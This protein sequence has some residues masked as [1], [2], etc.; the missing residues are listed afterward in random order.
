AALRSRESDAQSAL[1]RGR[2]D[3]ARCELELREAR[4]ILSEAAQQLARAK[5]TLDKALARAKFESIEA[6]RAAS[7]ESEAR[8][9]LSESLAAIGRACERCRAV[10]DERASS[11]TTEVDEDEAAAAER[12]RDEVR[13]AAEQARERAAAATAKSE[14]LTR[15]HDRAKAIRAEIAALLPRAERLARIKEVVKGGQLSELAAERHLEAVTARAAA[16]L[17]ELSTD[18][19]A[20]VRT[21]NGSFAVADGAHGGMVRA[22]STLSGGETFLVSLALALALSE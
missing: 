7:M 5:R 17:R 1:E 14:E 13:A 2:A 18:R 8:T 15:R 6:L 22:P 20:L 21:S 16:L 12:T 3:A 11:V 19:Y 4:A 10:F 9:A